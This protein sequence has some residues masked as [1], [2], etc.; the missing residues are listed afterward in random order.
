MKCS[1]GLA[2]RSLNDM[3]CHPVSCPS[4]YI[5]NPGCGDVLTVTGRS[6]QNSFMQ[7]MSPDV[8]VVLVYSYVKKKKK[9]NKK[10][11]RI[12]D[13]SFFLVKENK[14]MKT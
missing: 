5:D 4:R 9:I 11:T 13:V 8:I 1:V 12:R 14:K 6:S 2:L 3:L 10:R 7:T